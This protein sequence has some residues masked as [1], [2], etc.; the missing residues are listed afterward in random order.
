MSADI[1]MHCASHRAR[2]RAFRVIPARRGK[3][4][5]RRSTGKG[6]YPVTAAEYEAVKHIPGIRRFRPGPDLMDCWS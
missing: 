4:S 2:E 3:F 6:V 5:L 1:L